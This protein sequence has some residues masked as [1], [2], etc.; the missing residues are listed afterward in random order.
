MKTSVLFTFSFFLFTS[1]LAA[2]PFKLGVARYTVY[3]QKLDD[4]LAMM[5]RIDCRYLAFIDR[6]IPYEADEKAI[7]DYEAKLAKYGVKTATPGPLYFSEEKYAREFFGLAKR[8]GM[9]TVSVVPFKPVGKKGKIESEE[10]LDLL[11]KLVKEYD[12]RAAIH[13]HGPDTPKLFPDADSIMKRIAK[14]DRRIGLCLDIGHERRCGKDPAETI[15][16]YADRIYDV[17]VK[18]IEVKG[19][20]NLAV[21][22][23]RGD[24]D[25]PS[26]FRALRDIG[27]D[28][29]CLIEYEKDFEAVEAPLLESFAY[30]RGVMDAVGSES[31]AK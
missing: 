29:Y 21:P 10:S 5:Q 15:R 8:W 7:A 3:K 1:A 12:I 14:R 20:E 6:T 13:N 22:G 11:E 23:P 16:R 26:V 28:G 17:H 31:P 18:N 19:T 27:Y 24:I 30:Y 2:V 25:I 9:K 4:A